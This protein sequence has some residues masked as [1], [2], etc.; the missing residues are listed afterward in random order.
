MRNPGATKGSSVEYRLVGLEIC[1]Q[2]SVEL[3]TT[4]VQPR[5]GLWNIGMLGW[6]AV[7]LCATKGW[8]VKYRLVGLESCKPILFTSNFFSVAL[9]VMPHFF[10]PRPQYVVVAE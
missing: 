1:K 9:T 2:R 8:P 5:V 6:R 7:K 10:I 3:C 4:Q